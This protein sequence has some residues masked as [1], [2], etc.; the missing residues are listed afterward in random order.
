MSKLDEAIAFAAT[1]HADQLR[2]YS[3]LPYI[4]HPIEVMTICAEEGGMMNDE[5]ALMAAVLHDVLEDTVVSELEIDHRFGAEVLYMVKELTDVPV[6]FG[7]RKTRK[8]ED[9]RRL[10]EAI[11]RVQT[12]KLADLISNTKSI[13]Q[14]DKDFAKTYLREK[15]LVLDVLTRGS[16]VLRRRAQKSLQHGQ[17]ELM[18]Y[19]LSQKMPSIGPLS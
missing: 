2:K 11:P 9:R 15:E 13:V 10:G 8:A 17:E 19:H 14:H 1:A 4:I 5:P 6:S 12:I 7:N 3:N 18:A 16:P